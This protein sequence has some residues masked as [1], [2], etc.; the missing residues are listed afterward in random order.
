M[1]G[2][3][4]DCEW[5]NECQLKTKSD[6]WSENEWQRVITSDIEWQRMAGS[7][8]KRIILSFK[9]KQKVNLVPEKLYSIFYAIYDYYIFSNIDNL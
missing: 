7:G 3:T 5:S 4:N 1:S 6:K 9:M 8:K 2:T